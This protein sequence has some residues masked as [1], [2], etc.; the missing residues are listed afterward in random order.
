MGNQSSRT[1]VENIFNT[2]TDI[3]LKQKVKESCDNNNTSTN[4]VI[5]GSGNSISGG[6]TQ[7]IDSKFSCRMSTALDAVANSK[8]TNQQFNKMKT[9]MNQKGVNLF[10]RQINNQN[11][12]NRVNNITNINQLQ[13]IIKSCNSNQSYLNEV[14][15]GD[16]NTVTG[17]IH[18]GISAAVDC[19]FETDASLEGGSSTSNTASNDAETSMTQTGITMMASCGSSIVIVV[20]AMVVLFIMLSGSGKKNNGPNMSNMVKMGMRMRR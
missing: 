13:E 10:Q 8:I 7:N 6:I 3:D 20:I 9:E 5:L 12:R 14:I 4:R 19:I 18:Q 1:S 11:A 16:N 15:G 2:H 17:G